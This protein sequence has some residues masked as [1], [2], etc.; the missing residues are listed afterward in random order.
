MTHFPH[1]HD[2]DTIIDDI[3]DAVC[4][5]PDAPRS[6]MDA[7]QLLA[8]RWARI[9]AQRFDPLKILGTA[10]AWSAAMSRSAPRAM[11]TW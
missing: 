1:L 5:D 6:G 10:A 9:G 8:S 11:R 3:E 2:A 7:L 4:T